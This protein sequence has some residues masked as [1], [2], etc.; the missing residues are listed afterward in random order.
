MPIDKLLSGISSNP[1]LSG[2]LGGAASGALVTAM[3]D[4]KSAKTLVKAGG[5]VAVGGLAWS[6]Y[7]SYKNGQ[8]TAEP[9]A[10]PVAAPSAH[11][12]MPPEVALTQAAAQTAPVTSISHQEPVAQ[13]LPALQAPSEPDDITG[14][15][16]LQAMIGA[17]HADGQLDDH[18]RERIWEHALAAEL[19]NDELGALSHEIEHPTAPEQLAAQVQN[20]EQ[21]IQIYAASKLVI[22]NGCPAG[23]Q[24][25]EG[26]IAS[27]SLP[28]GLVM[29]LNKQATVSSVA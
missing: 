26:L 24:Y 19:S 15:L 21:K 16:I 23:E 25:L 29:A 3:L 27:L 12:D 7:Q 4:K 17:A 8:S 14:A 10:T 1:A 18:E 20:M 28:K 5:L 2:A 9:A 6:A 22:G 11:V 13:E